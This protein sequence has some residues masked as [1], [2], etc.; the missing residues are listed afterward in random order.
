MQRI[1]KDKT[2]DVN[3]E[4]WRSF[5]VHRRQQRTLTAVNFPSLAPQWRNVWVFVLWTSSGRLFPSLLCTEMILL[6]KLC[7]FTVAHYK[8]P[9]TIWWNKPPNKKRLTDPALSLCYSLVMEPL[10]LEH[11]L[12]PYK[13]T[14][15]WS[16][17]HVP[18]TS[19]LWSRH[20]D[21]KRHI[22]QCRFPN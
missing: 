10:K 21:T 16:K 12:L 22:N 17:V 20:L 5:L 2:E 9:G 19:W 1:A 13:H 3:A 11:F 15:A 18:G 8:E 6:S 4:A 7:F 14:H